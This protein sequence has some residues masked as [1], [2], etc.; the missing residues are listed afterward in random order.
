M[1]VMVVR[2]ASDQEVID[3]MLR[4]VEQAWMKGARTQRKADPDVAAHHRGLCAEGSNARS[5]G[6]PAGTRKRIRDTRQSQ[7]QAV[8]R[9]WGPGGGGAVVGE[10]GLAR[11]PLSQKL[12][13]Y[14]RARQ[15]APHKDWVGAGAEGVGVLRSS[16]NY[17]H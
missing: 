2:T 10:N 17:I 7:D 15:I 13:H 6:V 3:V 1:G 11:P 5:P 4:S 8:D 9:K 16:P 14:V 12:L